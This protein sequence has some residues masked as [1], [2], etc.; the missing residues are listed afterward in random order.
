LVF[1]LCPGVPGCFGLGGFFMFW[2]FFDHCVNIFEVIVYALNSLLYPLYSVVDACI[3]SS[4][5]LF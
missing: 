5:P 2:I 4:R 1:S 3:C